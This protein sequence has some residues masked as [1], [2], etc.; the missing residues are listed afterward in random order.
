MDKRL[1]IALLL[2]A[3]IVYACTPR[4]HANERSAHHASDQPMTHGIESRVDVTTA[5]TVTFL[6]ELTNRTGKTVELRFP[7]AQTHDFAVLNAKGETVWQWSHDRMF[8]QVLRAEP[9]ERN[10]QVT[11]SEEWRAAKPGAYTLVATATSTSHPIEER[12]VFTVR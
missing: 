12:T 8:T 5:P 6:L 1:A 9:I 10:Q 7:T 11:Y 3:S 2:I 4:S